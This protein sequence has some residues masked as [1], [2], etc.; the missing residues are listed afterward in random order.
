MRVALERIGV[1]EYNLTEQQG[2]RDFG[3]SIVLGISSFRSYPA[4]LE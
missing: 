4:Q 1:V 3:Q 2:H